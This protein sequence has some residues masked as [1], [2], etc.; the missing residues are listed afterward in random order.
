MCVDHKGP[1]ARL[2]S[3]LTVLAARLFSL[4]F[5]RHSAQQDPGGRRFLE[6][7]TLWRPSILI[8]I[9]KLKPWVVLASHRCLSTQVL[10]V[11]PWASLQQCALVHGQ[12]R[13]AGIWAFLTGTVFSRRQKR[14]L[15]VSLCWLTFMRVAG[16][17]MRRDHRP[18]D[19]SASV[20][21]ASPVGS[22]SLGH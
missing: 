1:Q 20:F 13:K 14:S 16:V 15:S 3:R 21:A 8:G 5:P 11:L 22:W 4:G 2:G 17:S 10:L 7:L 19:S 18:E 12:L 6:Q 9:T